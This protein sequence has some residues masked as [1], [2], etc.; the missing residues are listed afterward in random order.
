VGVRLGEDERRLLGQL[1]VLVDSVGRS[2][3]DPAARRLTPN[4]FPSDAEAN[5]EFVRLIGPEI[6]SARAY[7]RRIFDETISRLGDTF[8]ISIDEAEAWARLIG[9]SRIVLGAR[10]GAFEGDAPDDVLDAAA[11]SSNLAVG[12][13]EIALLHY[14]GLLQQDL[15]GIL[16][17][18]MPADAGGVTPNG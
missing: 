3:N 1:G 10:L 18:T 2:A 14:L 4:A 8:V 9:E 13:P 11:I 7:D 16:L 5:H 15:V 6:Q 12:R 17:E